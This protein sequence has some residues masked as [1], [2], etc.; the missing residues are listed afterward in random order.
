MHKLL[1]FAFS[2]NPVECNCT[3]RPTVNFFNWVTF[4]SFSYVSGQI[5]C[6]VAGD[7]LQARYG[8]ALFGQTCFSSDNALCDAR[9]LRYDSKRSCCYALSTCISKDMY[10]Y[11]VDWFLVLDQRPLECDSLVIS[12]PIWPTSQQCQEAASRPTRP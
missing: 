4:Q 10:R 9:G 5:C 1:V 3:V 8:K 7:Q 11:A 2:S 12:I 6:H